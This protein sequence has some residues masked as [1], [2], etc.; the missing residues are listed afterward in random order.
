MAA[1]RLYLITPP[2]I[3]RADIRQAALAAALDA[4]DVAMRAIAGLKDIDDDA[5][6]RAAETRCA[7]SRNRAASPSS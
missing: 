1:S 7:R 3:E 6:R 4:G 2:A 5:I